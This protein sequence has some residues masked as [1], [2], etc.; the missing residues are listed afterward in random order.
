VM[1]ICYGFISSFVP[2]WFSLAPREHLSTFLKIGAIAGLA[3]G[4]LFVMPPL[5]MA[6]VTR[7]IDGTG[8][9]FSRALFPFL[10]ITIACGAVSGFHAL[11]SSGTT[12]K[13]IE[14][15]T[16]IPFIG[17]GGMLVESFVAIMAMVAAS[18][19]EPGVYFAMN[20]PSGLIGTDA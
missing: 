19:I 15:E 5:K 14:N 12:P 6:A 9:V 17:Y 3:L 7:F 13:M 16:Q 20:S 8:P 11:I 2:V 10:F 1:L 4:I 18:V